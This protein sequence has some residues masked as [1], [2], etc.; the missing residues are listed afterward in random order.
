MC[1]NIKTR[2]HKKVNDL[3]VSIVR[4]LSNW[5]AKKSRLYIQAMRKEFIKA[6]A[7]NILHY[8]SLTTKQLFTYPSS[9]GNV[10]G[11]GGG[12]GIVGDGES[13]SSRVVSI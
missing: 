12:N 7:S 11:G 1:I 4:I 8:I 3:Y 10:S 2:K 9:N 13:P 5:G 6:K